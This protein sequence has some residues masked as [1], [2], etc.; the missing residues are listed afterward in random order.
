MQEILVKKLTYKEFRALE[1]ED[2]DFARYELLN[3]EIVKK[4]SPSLQHQRISGN[5]YFAMRNYLVANPIGE[6]FAAPLD[7]VLEEHEAPQPD[8]FFVSKD[9]DFVLNEAEGVVIGTPDLIVEIISPTSVRRDRHDKKDLYEHCGVR[10]YWLID[11]QNRSIEVFAY[12]N[13]RYQLHSFADAEGKAVS[14]V[15]PDFEIEVLALIPEK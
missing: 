4:S 3:G 2:N 10:E 14:A 13:N 5:I 6:V 8:V 11:P 15:L 1:F 7:V 12:T 9:R